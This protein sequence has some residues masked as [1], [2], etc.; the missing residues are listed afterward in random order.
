MNQ[1]KAVFRQFQR[2]TGGTGGLIAIILV[3]AV[4]LTIFAGSYPDRATG[5]PINR[6]LN[7][8]VLLQLATDT[9]FFAIMAICATMV[10]VTG[11]IDLSVGSVYALAG[12]TTALL[13]RAWGI[14]GTALVPVALALCAGIGLF[15]GLLNGIMVCRL[16]VHPFIITLGTMWIYRGISFVSSKAESIPVGDPLMQFAKSTLGLPGQLYPVPLLSMLIVAGAGALYL[17]RTT[18]GRRIFA[19]G[20]NLEAARYAGLRINPIL[21]G[22][23]VISGLGAGIA[24][25]M[26]TAYY[27][28]ASCSDANG[29]ELYVVASAVVGGASLTGG[30]GSAWGALLGALLITLIRQSIRILGLD[31][32]YEQIII[33]IAIIVAVVIDRWSVRSAERSL[34]LARDAARSEPISS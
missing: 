3:A 19:V 2:W 12:V 20:G 16:G 13:L 33:G 22:V 11:G 8:D 27:G 21:T 6:F 17:T 7:P 32:N 9:S 34:V 24:A 14:Q 30:K 29:Y 1:I 26:G 10:I 4:L 28:A 25:F 23:Y 15:A 31:Q 5:Q 18:M